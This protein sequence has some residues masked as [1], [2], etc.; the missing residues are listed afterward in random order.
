MDEPKLTQEYCLRLIDDY[1]NGRAD[2]SRHTNIELAT[3]LDVNP[4]TISKWRSGSR[5]AEKTMRQVAFFCRNLKGN[6]IHNES[7]GDRQLVSI[8]EL[9]DAIMASDLC[10]GCKVKAYAIIKGMGGSN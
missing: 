9:L 2:G 5:M 1:I 4:V 8:A 7:E 10:D 3:F 6:A